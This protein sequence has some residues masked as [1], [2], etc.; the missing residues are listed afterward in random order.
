MTRGRDHSKFLDVPLKLRVRFWF[1]DKYNSI[2]IWLVYHDHIKAARIWW[3][4]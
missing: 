3:R 4:I 1:M 2:G